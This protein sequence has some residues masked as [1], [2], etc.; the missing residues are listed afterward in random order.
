MLLLF[1]GVAVVDAV[2]LKARCVDAARE[3]ALAASRGGDAAAAVA[4]VAP[5]RSAVTVTSEGE[6]VRVVVR[7]RPR[8]VTVEADAV[9]AREPGV[10]GTTT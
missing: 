10:P 9:A 5:P 3:G 6:T 7:C 4:R 8:M 1:A 2:A